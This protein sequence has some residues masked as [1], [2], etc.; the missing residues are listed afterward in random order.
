MDILT[1]IISG[2][3]ISTLTIPFCKAE[4]HVKIGMV[5]AGCIGG[6]MPDIDALSMWSNFDIRIGNLLKLQLPG[7][8]I[9]SAK[10]WYSHHGFF[11]SLFAGLLFS[12]IIFGLLKFMSAKKPRIEKKY[13]RSEYFIAGTFFLAFVLH[14]FEDMPTPASS[15]GG[16]RFFW[17]SS[18]YIGGFGKIWWWNNYDIFL[19]VCSIVA[20]NLSCILMVRN[21]RVKYIFN[22][23]IFVLGSFLA[24]HQINTR[25]VE[26]KYTGH[27]V[28][29]YEYESQSLK[30]QQDILGDRLYTMMHKLDDSIPLH[31]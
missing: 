24:I 25:S 20:L 5:L 28:N 7:K 23:S 29:Y 12:F 18:S 22:L 1:H 6:A 11:H 8:E 9:Y 3:A 15:W 17:P 10:L 21:K 26:F 31:F 16:V 27:T 13:Y 30:I 19:L 4:T 2:L 14:L